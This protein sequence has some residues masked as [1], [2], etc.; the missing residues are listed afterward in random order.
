MSTPSVRCSSLQQLLACPASHV[1]RALV[2]DSKD[3]DASTLGSWCHYEAARRLVADH[4]AVADEGALIPVTMP[5]G[6]EA[7]RF[8]LWMVDFYLQTV[9]TYCEVDMALEVEAEL[10]HAFRHFT[11][12]GHVD[13]VGFKVETFPVPDGG[14]STEVVT[15]AVGLDLK[16]GTE[17]VDEAEQ[18]A[19]VLGYMVL[20]RLCYP[21]L[22]KVTFAICQPRNNPDEGQERITWATLE[23]DALDRAV[24]YAEHEIN[25]ALAN[26]NQ[27]NSDGW[28]QCRYCPAA[29]QCPAIAGD[30]EA[31]KL[32][33]TPEHIANIATEPSVAR[34]LEI[35]FARKKLSPLF[36]RAKDALKSRVESEGGEII[37]N[38]V[39][40]YVE[41][42]N[43]GRKITDNKAATEALS[44]LPDERFH[45][46]YEFKPAAIEAVLAEHETERTGAKVPVESK[47]KGKVSGKSLFNEKLGTLTETTTA[48]WLRIAE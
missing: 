39:R 15:E 28:K 46:T 5:E 45:R 38:G 19:Q 44:D 40:I 25:A 10:S 32:T 24:T 30:I 41:E 37:E 11:L 34:L 16:T 18:N 6:W 48:K 29:D 26:P 1:L 13:V 9:L 43:S 35:E 23:G 27:L 21:T 4:G 17:I 33:L 7:P 47:A 12:T 2:A 42:R 36:D 14:E 8:A 31:M 3:S 22:R 20:L